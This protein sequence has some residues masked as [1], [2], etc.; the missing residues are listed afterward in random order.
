MDVGGMPALH[1]FFSHSEPKL[2]QNDTMGKGEEDQ[3]KEKEEHGK[4]KRKIKEKV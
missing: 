2:G 4:G 1:R 3:R